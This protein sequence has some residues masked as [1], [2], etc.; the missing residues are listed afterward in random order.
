MTSPTFCDPL[1][2]AMSGLSVSPTLRDDGTP[3]TKSDDGSG[4]STPFEKAAISPSAPRPHDVEKALQQG[5]QEA[6]PSFEVTFSG[7]EDPRS[8]KSLSTLRKWMIVLVVSSTSLCV[9]CTSSLYTGTYAQV[10]EEFGSDP[11]V[12]TLGLSMFVVG[13]G[14][15]PMVL[16]PLSEVR[17]GSSYSSFRD[18]KKKW[19][20][21]SLS[22]LGRS[23]G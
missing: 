5:K 20:A 17:R 19:T 9:A 15:S 14:L 13:L 18:C 3:K 11:T 2:K 22:G 16:A 12:T 1:T 8:P 10:M 23:A 21:F 6:E 7:D 4:S